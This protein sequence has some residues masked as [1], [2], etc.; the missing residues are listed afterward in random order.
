MPQ[1]NGLDRKSLQTQLENYK[2]IV[3]VNTG[4]E[5]ESLFAKGELAKKLEL[6]QNYLN[7]SDEWGNL[8]D[9][10]KSYD[11]LSIANMIIVEVGSEITRILAENTSPD[12]SD[13]PFPEHSD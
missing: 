9:R 12:D 6:A 10:T 2:L 4:L 8:G 11:A 3:D 13:L 1:S 5:D 7:D